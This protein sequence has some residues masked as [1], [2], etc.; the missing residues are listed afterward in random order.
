M[1]ATLYKREMKSSWKLLLIFTAILTMYVVLMIVMYTPEMLDMFQQFSATMPQLMSSFN[2]NFSAESLTLLGY[3]AS[4]LYGFILIIFPMI[5]S[6]I[7]G[8][9]LVA[10]YVDR[11]SMASLLAAPV[12]RRTVAVTQMAVLITGIV[13][14]VVYASALELVTIAAHAPEQADTATLLKLNFGLLSLHLFIGGICFLASCLFSESRYSL[15]LGAGLPGLMYILQLLSQA[16]DQTE[17]F[18]Y[19]TFFTLFD[20][21]AIAAGQAGAMGGVWVLLGG[22]VILYAAAVVIFTKRDLSV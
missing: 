3:L 1:N 6:I 22:A 9:G 7:R 2:M 17:G 18:K 5:F 11:G 8:N 14:L 20:S 16:G 13:W 12:K 10:R 4:G 15:A 19:A 21:D